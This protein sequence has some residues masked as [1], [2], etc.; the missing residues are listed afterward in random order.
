MRELAPGVP[1][2]AIVTWPRLAAG[3][4]AFTLNPAQQRAP[5]TRFASLEPRL[6]AVGHGDEVREDAAATVHAFAE[7][8]P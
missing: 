4:R 2:D 6:V 3:R 1:G 8:R 5:L 7:Q